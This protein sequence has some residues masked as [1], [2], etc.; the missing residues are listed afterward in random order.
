VVEIHRGQVKIKSNPGR[1]T[2]IRVLLPIE[3]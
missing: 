3:R 1:G 2:T